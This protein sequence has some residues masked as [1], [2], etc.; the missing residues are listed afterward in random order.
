MSCR[1]QLPLRTNRDGASKHAD[2]WSGYPPRLRRGGRL[3]RRQAQTAGACRHAP[4]SSRGFRKEA[5]EGGRAE[6][7]TSSPGYE[8]LLVERGQHL[9]LAR[10]F[11]YMWIGLGKK[12]ADEARMQRTVAD[13]IRFLA[14]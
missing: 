8:P 10:F 11:S 12:M 4:A 14:Q 9:V 6:N 7:I 3:G 5:F 13:A 2:H 1:R